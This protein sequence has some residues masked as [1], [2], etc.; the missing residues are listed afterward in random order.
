MLSDLQLRDAKPVNERKRYEMS[1]YLSYKYG[2][3]ASRYALDRALRFDET[4]NPRTVALGRQW[5]RETSDPRALLARAFQ[6]YNREF[7]YTLEPPTLDRHDPYDDFLFTSKQG[8]CEHYAG[9]FAL[10]MRAAGIPARVVTG[11]QGGEVN[12]LNAE[13][14][15][16]QAD[17]HAWVELWV[18]GEGWV[19][20]DPTAAVSPLRVES[21][22]NAALGPIGVYSSIIAADPLGL[23]ANLR[24]GWQFM[25]S[26]W[27]QWVVG[28]NV[29]RQRQFFSQLGFPSIDWRMLG[30]WLMVATFAV[31]GA[32]TLGLLVRDRPPRREA[33]LVAWNRYCAKLAAI[34]VPRDPSE[35]P[36]DYLARVRA[37]RPRSAVSAAEIT[38]RYVAARY[39][40]GATR[41]ELRALRR[42]VRDFHPA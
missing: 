42:L 23:L 35:G 19:R 39:G 18:E 2:E 4:R 33:S 14:I 6:F 25:N 13:L 31:G 26:H 21:G 30:F 8:F 28:Y 7:T 22:V 3:S 38:R 32:V 17:A 29:D 1:S 10:L 9:S 24:Y 20:T 37:E 40:T 34:G 15:V 12:P 27:D 36:V 11:Y 5:A 16:R 41:E